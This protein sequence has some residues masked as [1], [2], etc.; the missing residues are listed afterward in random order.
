MEL[1]KIKSVKEKIGFILL[2]ILFLG[3][4]SVFAGNILVSEDGLRGNYYSEDGNAGATFNFTVVGADGQNYILVYE[5]GLVVSEPVNGTSGGNESSGPFDDHATLADDLVSYYSFDVDADDDYG[6]NDGTVTGA[7]LTTSDGGKIDEAYSFDGTDD[8]VSVS[9]SLGIDGSSDV[10]YSLWIKP[11]SLAT[12]TYPAFFSRQ[13]AV[14]SV[15]YRIRYDVDT[16]LLRFWRIKSGVGNTGYTYS[17][18]LSTDTWYYLTLTY[19]GSNVRGYVA[20]SYVGLG[21]S[22]G[23]G[24]SLT[25]GFFIG[26][27]QTGSSEFDGIVDEVGVWERALNSTEISDLYNSGDGLAY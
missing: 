9:S 6:S 23:N 11:D 12:G 8:Y 27:G 24:N 1:K 20:G 19:D 17:I 3:T 18:T 10:S 14:E 26:S 16:H 2:S 13:T 25:E 15:E 22:S 5:N 7:T 21:A 4:I